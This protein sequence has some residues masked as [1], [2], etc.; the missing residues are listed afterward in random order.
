[1]S[2]AF[3]DLAVDLVFLCG[4]FETMEHLFQTVVQQ[5]QSLLDRVNVY[6]ILIQ[7]NVSQN[8][9]IEAIELGKSLLQKLGID[10]PDI[11]TP[12]EIEAGFSEIRKLIG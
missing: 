9:P 4:D 1:M 2:L 12:T 5:A 10:F 7:A 6:Q 3:H 11:L 8:K